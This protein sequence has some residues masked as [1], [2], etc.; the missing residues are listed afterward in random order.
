MECIIAKSSISKS[1]LGNPNKKYC[2]KVKRN[3]TKK[4]GEPGQRSSYN[5]NITRLRRP[6]LYEKLKTDKN[7]SFCYSPNQSDG[8]SDKEIIFNETV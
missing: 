2:Y 6:D 3:P 5:D 7:L 4:N 8:K 1:Y